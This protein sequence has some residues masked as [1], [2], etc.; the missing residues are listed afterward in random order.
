MRREVT[1]VTLV[2]M[3]CLGANGLSWADPMGTA[4][5][6][7]G[8]LKDGGQ[9]AS[10]QYDFEFELYDAETAGS[11]IGSTITLED[12]EVSN[13]LFT[14]KLDFGEDVFTGD[15]RWLEIAVKGP[16]DTEYT[17]LTPRQELT[18]TPY[19]MNADL[20]DGRSS[21]D[22]AQ[23]EWFK[24]GVGWGEVVTHVLDIPHIRPFMVMVGDW[25]ASPESVGVL[26]CI[27]ND[28]WLVWFGY[29][30]AGNQYSDAASLWGVTTMMTLVDGDITVETPGDG[31]YT[32]AFTSDSHD[33]SGT[34]TW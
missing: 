9:P 28:G 34:V 25:E 24:D 27:E 17:T 15:A 19:A 3:L 5:T 31:S 32:I 2:A 18:P 33:F 12:V 8:Q 29:D 4:F 7:Q 13:A 26:W 30:N 20:L 11:Q 14:A 21:G 1:I 16:E 10:G 6:Y 23:K 22:F